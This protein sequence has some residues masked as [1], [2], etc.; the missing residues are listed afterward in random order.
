MPSSTASTLPSTRNTL[1]D[2]LRCHEL[3]S[4]LGEL[5]RGPGVVLEVGVGGAAA[6]A[7]CWRRVPRASDSK[8]H[9]VSMRHLAGRREDRRRSTPTTGTANTT[10]P[11][12]PIVEVLVYREWRF[13][14]VELLVGDIPGPDRR[15][16][17]PG[18]SRSGSCHCD[19]DVYERRRA[20]SNGSGLGSRTVASSSS[21]T[22]GSRRARA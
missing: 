20:C 10:T 4:L 19:V 9:R 7:R 21:T 5:R 16:G 14:N 22:M 6:L 17:S 13:D 1:V 11:L 3:W 2:I 12:E 8:R 15:P 18:A